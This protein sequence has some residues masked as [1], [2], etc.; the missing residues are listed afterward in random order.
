MLPGLRCHVAMLLS[1]QIVD[2]NRPVLIWI[3]EKKEICPFG[4][5]LPW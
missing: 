2:P 4:L 1:G 5:E 3:Y